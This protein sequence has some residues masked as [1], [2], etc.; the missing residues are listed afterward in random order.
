MRADGDGLNCYITLQAGG[1]SQVELAFTQMNLEGTNHA[2]CGRCPEGGCD[3]VAVFDGPDETSPLLG[4]FT[5]NPAQMPTVVSSGNTMHIR[6]MTDSG[7]CNIEGD[8][9]P[10]FFAQWVRLDW[11]VR[12]L[13]RTLHPC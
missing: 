8:E 10:G 2:G 4:H 9:D 13:S 1:D 3:Y 12:G 6:F 11:R 7:N 5:G